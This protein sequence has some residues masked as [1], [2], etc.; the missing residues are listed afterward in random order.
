MIDSNAEFA[1]VLRDLALRANLSLEGQDDDTA[2][3]MQA[4]IVRDF[5]DLVEHALFSEEDDR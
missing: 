3:R 1:R 2:R 5:A 4:D